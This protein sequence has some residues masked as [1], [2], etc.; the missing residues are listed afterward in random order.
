MMVLITPFLKA[1]ENTRFV[2]HHSPVSHS[3]VALAEVKYTITNERLHR[4]S[5]LRQQL[6]TKHGD[7][8]SL[9]YAAF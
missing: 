4:Q 5:L 8:L 2:I 7:S 1:V 6:D 3:N 9:R